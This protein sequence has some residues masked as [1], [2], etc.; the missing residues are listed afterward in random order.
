MNHL[1]YRDLADIAQRLSDAAAVQ[2]DRF[3]QAGASVD[4]A[5]TGLMQVLQR[6]RR[7]TMLEAELRAAERALADEMNDENWAR[8]QAIQVQLQNERPELGEE[9]V[10]GL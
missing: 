8:L 5:E 1:V 10:D 4:E 3:A 2:N 7:T 6:H 9:V